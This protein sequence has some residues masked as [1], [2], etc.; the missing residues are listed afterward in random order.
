VSHRDW[1]I[2]PRLEQM[3]EMDWTDPDNPL[4]VKE[5]YLGPGTQSPIPGSLLPELVP[6]PLAS[7][8]CR[9]Y[10][11]A[12]GTVLVGVP[13]GAT[14]AADWTPQTVDEA[15]SHFFRIMGFPAKP[16]LIE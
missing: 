1:Y 9:A 7:M 13:V 8:V 15:R 3:V 4:L 10:S 6:S 16:E 2:A 12:E 11:T 14:V 5:G